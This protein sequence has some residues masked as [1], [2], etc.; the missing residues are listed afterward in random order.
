MVLKRFERKLQSQN[1]KFDTFEAFCGKNSRK[2]ALIFNNPAMF[3]KT[4][5]HRCACSILL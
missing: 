5:V 4:G 1:Q 3:L 2:L